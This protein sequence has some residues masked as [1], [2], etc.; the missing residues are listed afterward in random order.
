[1][2]RAGHPCSVSISNIR[3]VVTECLV[4]L[5]KYVLW[6]SLVEMTGFEPATSWSRTKRAT[7]LRY[8][9]NIKETELSTDNS[10]TR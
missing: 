10:V 7:K 9:S 2:K 3:L 4:I 8:I 6:L 1:M 5:Q